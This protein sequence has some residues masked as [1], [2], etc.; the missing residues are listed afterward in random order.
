MGP[1][2]NI[3]LSARNLLGYLFQDNS[4]KSNAKFTYFG[5]DV[6]INHTLRSCTCGANTHYWHGASLSDEAH[7]LHHGFG[8]K[9]RLGSCVE[10][11][12]AFQILLVRTLDD[13]SGCS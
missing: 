8:H 3:D 4:I 11:S 2:R 13:E 5:L 9:V 12:T 6:K 7:F 10:E 1:I